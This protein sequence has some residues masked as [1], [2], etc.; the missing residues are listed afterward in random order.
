MLALRIAAICGAVVWALWLLIRNTRAGLVPWRATL[1]LAAVP[2]VLAVA[3]PLL[4]L[5]L[6]LK[7]Y[8]TAIPL[9][10]FE[11]ME[12]AILAMTVI[13]VFIM[14]AAAAA[15]LLSLFPQSLAQLRAANRGALALDAVTALTVA[16]GISVALNQLRGL[17][18][19]LFPAQAL[20][21]IG[22]PDLI[23]SSAPALAALA[24]A[25]RSTLMT[26]A[27]LAV[28]VMGI[29]KTPKRWMLVPLA[30]VAL[31]AMLSPDTHTPAEFALQYGLAFVGAGAY[32]LFCLWFARNNYLA[33]ALALW[34]MALRTPLAQL[35]STT[36]PA[37]Q[38]QAW[39]IAAAMALTLVWAAYPAFAR[40]REA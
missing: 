3:G 2:A 40:K 15:L 9:G 33:Y 6:L 24:D 5:P 12:Y 11:A 18:F 37:L 26:A 22:S 19:G 34:V 7:E 25:V 16:V 13:F 35:F 39:I 30:F 8:P 14:M 28:I 38:V 31:F 17:L 23:V 1:T 4:S 20:F 29:R 27:G 10:T 36:N 21:S 32:A